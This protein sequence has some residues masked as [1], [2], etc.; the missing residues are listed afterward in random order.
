MSRLD[1]DQSLISIDFSS[2]FCRVWEF[3]VGLYMISI[4][5]DS[6]LFAAIY[7]AVESASTA[8]FGPLVGHWVDRFTHIKVLASLYT[9]VWILR[10]KRETKK[11]LHNYTHLSLL[12]TGS[13]ALVGN[14]KSLF[15]YCWRHCD[16]I[17][18]LL[19]FKP[20]KF[21][22]VHH[23]SNINQRR[24]SCWSYFYSR[25]HH[26]SWKRLVNSLINCPDLH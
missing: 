24:R 23:A 4:W 6:L 15:Y 21:S 5:P 7:G 16:G 1:F 3:S 20:H 18:G 13:P 11:L 8:L 19:W 25:R 2:V 14:T 12:W 10:R 22:C 9:C 17:T 26:L